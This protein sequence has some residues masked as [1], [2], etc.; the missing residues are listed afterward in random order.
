MN[1]AIKMF[2]GYGWI[3][4]RRSKFWPIFSNKVHSKLKLSKYLDNKSCSSI[5]IF[6]N[7]KKI[8]KMQLIFDIEK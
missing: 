2:P 5:F 6:C 3:E 7:E 4:T 8:R 1:M